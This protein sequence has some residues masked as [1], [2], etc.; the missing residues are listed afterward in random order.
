MK[1][2]VLGC[3]G[4]AFF[5]KEKGVCT[6]YHSSCFQVNDAVLIDAG[7]ASG[8]LDIKEL[9]RL[10]YVFIS[11]A[12]LDHTHSLPFMAENLFGKIK[13]PVVI[14]STEK[15]LESLKAHLFNNHIW[16]D[17]TAIPNKSNP[18]LRY[19]T[20]KVGVPVEREGLKIT[21]I[22]VNHTVPAVGFLVEDRKSA[23]VYS[24]DTYKT[25][26]IWDRAS[27]IKSLKTAFIESTFPN[28]F[29]ELAFLSKHLTPELTY[30]EFLKINKKDIPFYLYHMKVPYLD[31]LKKDVGMIKDKRVHLPQDG[32]VLDL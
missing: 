19:E 24:G 1:V 3:Y 6:H 18:I 21:A 10:R 22:A 8:P 31:E 20:L 11:H 4:S 17:F 23:F 12:H 25:D 32:L 27:R 14:I 26:E 28:R 13:H 5:K 30:Q 15:I 29:S 16:P 7:T 2:R 9:V